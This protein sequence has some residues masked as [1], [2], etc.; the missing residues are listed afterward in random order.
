MVKKSRLAFHIFLLAVSM[1]MGA[2]AAFADM[3]NSPILDTPTNVTTT[4]VRFSW[5][6]VNNATYYYLQVY[7]TMQSQTFI[8]D[9]DEGTYTFDICSPFLDN[10]TVYNWRVFACNGEGCDYSESSFTNGPSAPPDTPYLLSPND[11]IRVDGLTA[12]FD[13]TDAAR[14]YHYYLQITYDA[15]FNN[16]SIDR[17]TSDSSEELIKCQVYTLDKKRR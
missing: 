5:Q 3:P 2:T 16:I 1:F 17:L 12:T 6:P 14:A 7:P 4:S 9:K 10:G 15:E 8:C 13:W 11:N